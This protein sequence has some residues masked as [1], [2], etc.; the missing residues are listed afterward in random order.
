[1]KMA[2]LFDLNIEQVLEHW[3]LEHALREIIANALDEQILT[4]SAKIKIFDD[5]DGR[6]HVR[7]YGRGLDHVH[8]TQNENKEKLQASNLIGKFGVGLKDALAVFNRHNV[9]VEINSKFATVTLQM[10]KKTGFN[11]ETLHAL[12]SESKNINMIGTEF[13]ISGVSADNIAKA[14]RMFLYFGDATLLEKTNFGEVYSINNNCAC[15]YVNG[16]QI[17][18]EY[19]FMFS[20]NITNISTQIKKSL[21]R[22]RSNV[23]RT[24][25]TDSIKKILMHC[26]SNNI[27]INLV[28]DLNNIM[29]G[30]NKDETSWIDISTYAAKT[31][32]NESN[33]VFL[34]PSE[35]SSLTNCQV[36]I[37]EQSGKQVILVT[38]SLKE[39]LNYSVTT[40]SNVMQDYRDSFEYKIV[41][42]DELSNHEKL[43]FD[44]KQIVID[45]LNRHK[46][47]CDIQINISETIRVNEY[48]EE[49]NGLF[50]GRRIIIKRKA[51]RRDKFL[52]VL[53]HEF[54]HYNSLADDN[55]RDFENILTD[56]LGF[57]MDELVINKQNI[58]ER[59]RKWVKELRMT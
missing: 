3:G 13:I 47:K 56:M 44:T 24:A 39:K 31:L 32:N 18:Q 26:K 6:W 57:A 59:T 37:L 15:I 45:F 30:I 22:E 7:D 25:Y 34:T 41:K 16:V 42:Y 4:E 28:Q 43:I 23:G 46:Y 2:K 20:Y 8:F 54:A 33:V 35:R 9:S 52:G 51:L 19:N 17:A 21:N 38:D 50:D 1:M 49:T 58:F 10:A 11:I 14:K 55:T 53:L 12:F 27:L 48:G 29:K 5:A 40:F 36:E